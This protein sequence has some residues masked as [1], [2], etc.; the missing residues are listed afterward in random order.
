M[1][2]QKRMKR[3]PLSAALMSSA[4]AISIGLLAMAS[5]H[6]ALDARETDDQVARPVGMHF[7][8]LAAIEHAGG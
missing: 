4:P 8:K 1:T 6:H 7:E 2:L 3:A 5:D